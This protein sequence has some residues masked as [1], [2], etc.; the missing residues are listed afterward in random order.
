MSQDD[1]IYSKGQ[2][3]YS[4]GID[5][6]RDPSDLRPMPVLSRVY[7]NSAEISSIFSPE[8]SAVWFGTSDGKIKDAAN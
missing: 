2:C 3:V 6:T 5:V 1:S 7:N 8:Q 4:H